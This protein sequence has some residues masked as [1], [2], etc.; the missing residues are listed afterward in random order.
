MLEESPDITEQFFYPVY[1]ELR[2]HFCVQK[3]ELERL[4]LDPACQWRQPDTAVL[5]FGSKNV[6]SPDFVLD[7]IVW[8]TGRADAAMLAIEVELIDWQGVLHGL[9]GEGLLFPQ[10][11]YEVSIGGGDPGTYR[12]VCEPPLLVRAGSLE[13]FKIRL[14]D[15][16]YA[17]NATA[18]ITLDYGK[19]KRLRLPALRLCT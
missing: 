2:Q 6:E 16:G 14:R 11:T 12:S 19:G 8:N 5:I 3:L 9:P 18:I 1:E 10:I 15:T 17:W 7:L 4:M 13:R